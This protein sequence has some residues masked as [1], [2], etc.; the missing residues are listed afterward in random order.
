MRGTLPDG[1]GERLVGTVTEQPREDRL[2]DEAKKHHDDQRDQRDQRD[3]VAAEPPPDQAATARR[4]E[5]VG[6]RIGCRLRH[7]RCK[8]ANWRLIE[9]SVMT[10]VS[11]LTGL[12]WASRTVTR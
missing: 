10:F 1:D 7:R 3:A 12:F 5:R 4:G 11:A 9:A 8:A 6:S 2:A